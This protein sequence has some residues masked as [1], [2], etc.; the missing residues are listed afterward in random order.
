MSYPR[1]VTPIQFFD[2]DEPEPVVAQDAP[3]AEEKP[4][5]PVIVTEGVEDAKDELPKASKIPRS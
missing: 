4:V 2:K 3:D 5:E 1:R